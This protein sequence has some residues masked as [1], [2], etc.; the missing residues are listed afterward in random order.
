MTVPFAPRD[1]AKICGAEGTAGCFFFA[2]VLAR[3]GVYNLILTRGRM[4]RHF[5][6]AA[7]AVSP[8]ATEKV[9]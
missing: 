7:C 8:N 1:A 4:V 3:L 2:M 6:A 9:N 5:R